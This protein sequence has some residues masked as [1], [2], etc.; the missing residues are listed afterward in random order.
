VRVNVATLMLDAS[1]VLGG[2]GNW[3]LFT[4][5][6]WAPADQFDELSPLGRSA[7]ASLMTDPTFKKNQFETS[8]DVANWRAWNRDLAFWRFMLRLWSN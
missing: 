6:Y 3:M 2:H 5:G 7:I 1:P 4:S 8:G